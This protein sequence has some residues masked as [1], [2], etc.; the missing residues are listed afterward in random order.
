[1]SSSSKP[2]IFILEIQTPFEIALQNILLFSFLDSLMSSILPF[3]SSHSI[4][5]LLI[6][7]SERFL[8]FNEAFYSFNKSRWNLKLSLQ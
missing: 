1:M 5:K 7:I 3:P 6:S 8:L 4:L 2:I